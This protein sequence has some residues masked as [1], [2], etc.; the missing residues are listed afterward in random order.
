MSSSNSSNNNN[1]NSAFKLASNLTLYQPECPYGLTGNGCEHASCNSTYV[2]AAQRVQRSDTTLC[3][4]CPDGWGGNL[5]CNICQRADACQLQQRATG[6]GRSSSSSSSTTS[7]ATSSLS[8]GGI[9]SSL[10]LA[11]NDT[12]VCV[13]T[14]RAISTT[15]V[16]CDMNQTTLTGIFQGNFQLSAIKTAGVSNA[17]EFNTV[18]LAPYNAENGTTTTQVWFNGVLQWGCQATNCSSFNSTD[19]ADAPSG[20]KGIV[21]DVWKCSTLNCVC[22]P[23]S[24]VCGSGPFD[25]TNTIQDLDGETTFACEYPSDQAA[26]ARA[27]MQCRFSGPSF[28][29]ALGPGGLPLIHCQAGACVTQDE[30]T[31]LWTNGGTTTGA[32]SD[33]MGLSGGVIA[34]LSVLGVVVATIL[35]TILA[36]LLLRRRAAN[37][38]RDPP[39]AAVGLAWS[40]IHYSFRPAAAASLI[41]ARG[42]GDTRKKIADRNAASSNS[43]GN[44]SSRNSEEKESHELRIAMADGGRG[45]I[46]ETAHAG[47]IL[48]DVSGEIHPGSMLAILGPSGAGKTS[49]VDILAGRSKVG[50][51]SGTLTFTPDVGVATS[52]NHAADRMVAFVDQEDVLPAFSTVR[53]ALQLAA[54]LS[55]PENVPRHERHEIV[56][57]V[58]LKLG[59]DGIAERRIGDAHRRGVSGGEKRR[60]SIGI[61]LVGQPK[62]LIMD[63]P[64][65]GLDAVNAQRVVQALREL[66]NGPETG[67][68]VIMTVHQPSSQIYDAFDRVML[69]AQGRVL[70][71]GAPHDAPAWLEARGEPLPANHNPA[72]HLLSAA[73]GDM[74]SGSS[75]IDAHSS[76]GVMNTLISPYRN[77]KPLASLST[78]VGSLASRA[79][80]A[81]YRDPSGALAHI[82][83]ALII[84]LITGGAFYKVNLT[85]AGFQNRV[86]S[87]FFL[88]LLLAFSAL[89]AMTGLNRARPLVVR[90]RGNGL[91]SAFSWLLSHLLYDLV[92]L[93]LIPT[94][95]LT[96][97]IYFMVGLTDSAGVFFRFFLIAVLFN[98]ATTLYFM[99]LAAFFEDMSIPTLLAGLAI[100][101]QLGFGGFLLNLNSV[102]GVLRWIK[103][104]CPLRYALEAMAT[105][106]LPGL[107][108]IDIV[109]GVPI[110][111]PVSVIAPNLFGF[112]VESYYRDL[113]VLALAFTLGFFLLLVGAVTWRMREVR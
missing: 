57:R 70:F 107:R 96:I 25:L 93:R 23:G 111:A 42:K 110:N 29:T 108:I 109:N 37:R 65:S 24:T 63:E 62:V 5:N 79:F 95:I 11:A 73:F 88:L 4:A 106:Q 50:T 92:M 38:P 3:T 56:N 7:A 52:S 13:N 83:G 30:L 82:L 41:P 101:F 71:D 39:T 48:R 46:A 19:P 91:Y 8:G 14:P 77:R 59:L 102:P 36:G 112:A 103:W 44:G 9:S 113:L 66:A 99:S 104:I 100:L 80:Q 75:D 20:R 12:A 49:L 33:G 58:L 34:G 35:A 47:H 105:I 10:A 81:S 85:I 74:G 60:I 54:Q 16:Q 1:N 78:Q 40:N 72:D 26:A 87:I 61:A 98:L 6:R 28:A 53:E 55:L 51:I 84:G 68:T 17:T 32:S 18:G 69:L 64:L 76:P 89:S 43:N 45:N 21:T 67:T 22:I 86:G 90:E 15:N 2:T 97:I 27:D 31:N 94:I